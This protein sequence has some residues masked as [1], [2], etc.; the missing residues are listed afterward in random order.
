MRFS[1]IKDKAMNY[2]G[3]F[4]SLVKGVFSLRREL[5]KNLLWYTH[6]VQWLIITISSKGRME[7]LVSTLDKWEKDDLMILI[8]KSN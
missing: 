7:I 1:L 3:E 6:K 5:V 8:Y 4:I 2:R